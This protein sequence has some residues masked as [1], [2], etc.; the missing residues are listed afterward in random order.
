MSHPIHPP[1]H[2]VTEAEHKAAYYKWLLEDIVHDHL[3]TVSMCRDEER[4]PTSTYMTELFSPD[5]G[6]KRLDE[7]LDVLF[8]KK[9]GEDQNCEFWDRIKTFA[10]F[11]AGMEKDL[12]D[13]HGGDCTAIACSCIRCWAEDLYDIPSTV[14]WNGK[15]EGSRLYH[16][17]KSQ[18]G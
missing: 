2:P 13:H 11:K 8:T 4:K 5:K 16:E 18:Q 6:K 17:W 15:H 10:E 9:A 7:L 3:L 14:T 1:M 12:A